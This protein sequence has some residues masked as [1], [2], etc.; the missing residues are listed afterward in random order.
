MMSS[1][2]GV[3]DLSRV[4][5]SVSIEEQLSASSLVKSVGFSYNDAST[6]HCRMKRDAGLEC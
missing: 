3:N 5:D 2:V 4:W 6:R 1:C